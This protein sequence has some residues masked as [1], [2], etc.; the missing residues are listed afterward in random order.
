MTRNEDQHEELPQELIDELRSADEPVPLITARVDREILARAESQFSSRKSRLWRR[1]PAWA[2]AAAT[3]L[4]ALFIF[5]PD[6]PR[7]PG[8]EDMY[9]DHDGSGRV[10]IADVFYVARSADQLEQANIDD[11]AMRVV[12]LSATGATP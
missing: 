3:V 6:A 11:F 12:A 7:S 5:R 8:F 2:A 9:A 4:V 10:D 1:Y